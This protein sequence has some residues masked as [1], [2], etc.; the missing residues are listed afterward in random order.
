MVRDLPMAV[1][2]V[3]QLAGMVELRDIVFLRVHAERLESSWEGEG[4]HQVHQ[5]PPQE[6]AIQIQE[7]HSE[8]RI[9]VRCILAGET[10]DGRYLVDAAA[11]YEIKTPV[12]LS[13]D[14]VEAFVEC[15][16]VMAIYPY[17]RETLQS[18][19]SKLRLDAPVLGLL[20]PSGVTLTPLVP[21]SAS[22]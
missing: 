10:R 12:A 17:L 6:I 1:G 18:A 9:E 3:A 2:D 13:Q 22:Q 14:L 7:R 21:R 4:V 5:G 19:A 20:R 11:Q 8:T 15:V 16:G